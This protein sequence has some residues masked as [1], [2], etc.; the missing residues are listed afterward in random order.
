MHP[1][2]I[3]TGAAALLGG[4]AFG[5][6]RAF[7]RSVAKEIAGNLNGPNKKVRIQT[8]F[9]EPFGIF[10]GSLR[11]ATIS[12]SEFSVEDMP[13]FVE[14]GR[15]KAG[16]LRLLQLILTN[17]NLRKL[18]V[19]EL[20][21]DVKD[22]RY[23]FDLAKRSKMVRLSR[24]GTGPGYAR[25]R[26]EDLATFIM[27]KYPE[28]SNVTVKLEK[29]KAFVEGDGDFG[30]FKSH[31]LV[32]SDF[33]TDKNGIAIRLDKAIVFLDGNR[34]RDG[35]ER[36]LLDAVNPVLDLDADLGLRG[37]LKVERMAIRPGYLE[38]FGT[39]TIPEHPG[40]IP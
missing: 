24:A 26:A 39:A 13:L 15:S 27:A 23:D 4:L 16:K 29:Y 7:E 36:A 2:L 21:A 12:A 6:I 37:A 35:S 31:F 28:L 5:E 9:E 17:F 8:A 10:S 30:V 25:L 40:L 14:P 32:I 3:A 20:T 38:V 1:W 22:C 33:A 18:H 34:V 19:E 11:R